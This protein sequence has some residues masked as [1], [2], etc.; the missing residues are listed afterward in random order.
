MGRVR[1]NGLFMPSMSKPAVSS[2]RQI[3]SLSKRFTRASA[4]GQSSSTRLVPRVRHVFSS[5][6]S[7]RD[8]F[9]Y[10][11]FREE[12]FFIIWK[13]FRYFFDTQMLL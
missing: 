3:C 9:R 13:K 1:K 8:H 2:S 5:V 11:H 7:R 10:W 6:G 4:R 12:I